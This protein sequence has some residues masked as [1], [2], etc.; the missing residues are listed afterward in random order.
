MVLPYQQ[1]SVNSPLPWPP[2]STTAIATANDPQRLRA[3]DDRTM[4]LYKSSFT[5]TTPSPA[6]PPCAAIV[7]DTIQWPPQ[8]S[9]STQSHGTATTATPTEEHP[10]CDWYPHRDLTS[11][12]AHHS[13]RLRHSDRR[14]DPMAS[15]HQTTESPKLEEHRTEPPQ[16]P[17]PSKVLTEPAI[18]TRAAIPATLTT[19]AIPLTSK[20]AHPWQMGIHAS[21]QLP[22]DAHP[23]VTLRNRLGL[24]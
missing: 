21:T 3:V 18:D 2:R 19:A 10:R 11:K 5:P 7:V 24:P 22:N 15:P 12:G 20:G 8:R 1:I 17:T 14:H 4:A 9:S 13:K 6:P 16:P 23:S